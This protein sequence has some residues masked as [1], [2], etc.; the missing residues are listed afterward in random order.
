MNVS[1]VNASNMYSCLRT[2]HLLFLSLIN[3]ETWQIVT[4]LIEVVWQFQPKT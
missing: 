1:K 2:Y 3:V 4:S